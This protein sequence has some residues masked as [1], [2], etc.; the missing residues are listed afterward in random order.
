MPYEN[1]IMPNYYAPSVGGSRGTQN[2]K[3]NFDLSSPSYKHPAER[4]AE[5]RVNW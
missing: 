3:P 5:N 1:I 4:P 2:P